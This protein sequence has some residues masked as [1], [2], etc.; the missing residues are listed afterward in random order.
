MTR[1]ISKKFGI[2]LIS[3]ILFLI[4]GFTFIPSYSFAEQ[5][6]SVTLK[7][8][9]AAASED[10]SVSYNGGT[11]HV[12]QWKNV[13]K[14][15]L[16]YSYTNQSDLPPK[17]PGQDTYAMNITIEYLQGNIDSDFSAHKTLENAFSYPTLRQSELNNKTSTFDLSTGRPINEEAA[18]IKGWGIYKFIIDINGQQIE[19][20]YYFIEPEQVSATPEIEKKTVPSASSWGNAYEFSIKNEEEF[21]YV[22]E[23]LLTW[24]GKGKTKDGTIYAIFEEDILLNL[25]LN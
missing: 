19:T 21:K 10:Y 12:F 18:K 17:S 13:D 16:K 9:N 22:N 3:L 15:V 7:K 6:F 8:D 1:K 5:V 4:L 14:I 20:D 24:Y 25:I 2:V 23:N 11:M